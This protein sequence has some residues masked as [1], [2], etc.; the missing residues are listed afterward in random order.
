MDEDKYLARRERR[1]S[2]SL[3]KKRPGCFILL[4]LLLILFT[5]AGFGAYKFYGSLSQFTNSIYQRVARD[6][7]RDANVSL[8]K[9]EPVSILLAG[10][11]NGALFYKDVPDGR[12]DVMMVITI[13]PENKKSQLLSVPR[14]AL[15]P[16][17]R[18]DDFDKLNHAYMDYGI[19]GTINSL[20]RYLDLPI[21][22]YVE[23]NMKGFI[24]IIDGMGGIEITPN[25]TFIQ[26]GAKF[27]EGV[28]RTLTGEEAIHYVRMRKADPEG[29]IGREKRQQQLVKAVIDKVLTLDTI[30]NFREIMAALGNNLKTDL[31]LNDMM[32]LQK[33]YLPALASI[34]RLVFKD[35][36]DLNLD[37]GYYLL[38]PEKER[39]EM[40]NKLR[41]NLGLGPTQK[42][43]VYPPSYG[44][45]NRYFRVVDEDE[46]G[47]ITD[48]DLLTSASD[49]TVADLKERI[50]K[51]SMKRG[52]NYFE[53]VYMDDAGVMQ[54]SVLY[55]PKDQMLLQADQLKRADR[56]GGSID[57]SEES[58]GQVPL[59]SG[60][61]LGPADQG[62][63][64]LPG[65]SGLVDP[66]LTAPSTGPGETGTEYAY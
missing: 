37:F 65:S 44:V 32:A 16:M 38:V 8:R 61:G 24:D 59:E 5:L 29:D 43:I 54:P 20:Q 47:Q 42:V 11:D 15:G 27:E 7:M 49:Y 10:I 14:D 23:V 19:K 21:D 12:S 33:N 30:T 39:R 64:A 1:R 63:S 3:K 60:Q 2:K 25:Q 18:T 46:D 56:F 52:I 17:D 13:D 41:A 9:G 36:Q 22:Y 45:V 31:S 28:T 35:H 6:N 48:D 26:N 51:A 53:D 62:P 40:S 58:G 4:G 55:T 66:S 57:P 50:H 34:E